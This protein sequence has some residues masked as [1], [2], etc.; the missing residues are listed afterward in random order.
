MTKPAPLHIPDSQLQRYFELA[1]D[2]FCIGDMNGLFR[3]VNAAAQSVLGYTESEMQTIKFLDLVHPDDRRRAVREFVRQAR[4]APTSSLEVRYRCKSGAYRRI[5]WSAWPH[6][7][8]GLVY[9]VGRDITEDYRRR[10]ERRLAGGISDQLWSMRT[11]Q[12]LSAILA[13]IRAALLELDI[14]FA[15]C[16]INHVDDTVSPPIVRA[17]SMEAGGSWQQAEAEGVR[18][19]LRSWL[20][21]RVLY[22]S[23]LQ[24]EDEFG[25]REVFDRL[26]DNPVR[27]VVDIPFSHGT[28]AVNASE[29]SAFGEQDLASLQVFADL[30]SQAFRRFEDVRRLQSRNDELE[31]E[32]SRRELAE[33]EL[34]QAHEIAEAASQSKSAFLA[35]TSHEIRTPL[36]AILGMAQILA[37]SELNPE[38]TDEVKTLMQASEGLVRVVDDILDLSKIEAGQLELETRPFAPAE[39]FEQVC[40]TIE[41][42][43]R[44]RGL[45][46]DVEIS[47]T[48]PPSLDGDAGRLRQI[49]LNLL[50]NAVKFT[51]QGRIGVHVCT[52]PENA[53]ELHIEVSDTGIGIPPERQA[54]IFEAFAQADSST[55]RRFGGTG[56][57]LSICRRLAQ[58]MG[59][60]IDLTSSEGQGSTFHLFI[61]FDPTT[62]APA[63]AVPAAVV[64]ET[65]IVRGLQVLLVE[66]NVLNRRVARALLATDEHQIIEA[67]NGRL[68]VEVSQQ[69]PFDLILMDIQMPEMDGFSATAAI[70]ELER[71][72]SSSRVPI[73][74]LTAHAMQEDRDRCLAAGMDD[75]VSKPIRRDA[76][77]QTIHRVMSSDQPATT[78]DPVPVAEVDLPVLD[79]G[80]LEELRELE[81][82]DD[83]FTIDGFV[84]L[85]NQSTPLL[86]EQARQALQEGDAKALHRHAHSLKGAARE[87]GAVKLAHEAAQMED[88]L[89]TGIGTSEEASLDSLAILLQEV[90]DTLRAA[91]LMRDES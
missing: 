60:R 2:L 81:A 6:L 20:E 64:E 25:E 59:G 47:P 61:P 55:T 71:S 82:I 13:A 29:P 15:A 66:D 24:S 7:E 31:E 39:L 9:A 77:R 52:T 10:H 12:D 84:A 14:P 75:F 42:R 43:V 30:L 78:V 79:P 80:P 68:G 32:I 54:A 45:T 86:L 1:V 67:E 57:G 87:V 17:H 48:L 35:N 63:L 91:R 26:F 18:I 41:P 28:L 73:I 53:Q 36:N 51:E 22:R 56:L 76:L 37:D 4:G 65:Q 85:F 49:L 40:R 50:S 21:E 69:Q 83:E 38:Q 5:A 3:R 62:Q 74:A 11:E 70:R 8:D 58:M 34:R 33:A 46:L 72:A 90:I 88:R 23:D 19:I 27:S 44:D 89:R 16:G